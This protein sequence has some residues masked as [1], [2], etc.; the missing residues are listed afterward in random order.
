M[1]VW[2]VSSEN[3]VPST[4]LERHLL[5]LLDRVEPVAA[6][7]DALRRSQEIRADFLCYWISATGDGGPE[8]SPSTLG[9]IGA[10]DASLGIDFRDDAA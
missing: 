4:S 8:V 10:L 9:R 2:L 6:A 5:H 7:I 1:G 3:A